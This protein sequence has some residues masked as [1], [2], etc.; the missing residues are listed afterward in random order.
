MTI[1]QT[2]EIPANRKVRFEVTLPES[3]IP[4]KAKVAMRFTPEEAQK[5]KFRIPIISWLEDRRIRKNIEAIRRAAGCLARNPEWQGD[6]VE[7]Q[8]QLRA[9]WDRPWDK[10][11]GYGEE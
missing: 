8:R 3:V 9:E 10:E 11:W 1:T 6:A 5:R 7:I 2:V 4:G